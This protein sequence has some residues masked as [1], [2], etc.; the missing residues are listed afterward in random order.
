MKY[1]TKY[2]ELPNID[3]YQA[4]NLAI[5]E[6]KGYPKF[7]TSIYASESPESINGKYYME[8]GAHLQEQWPE[9][10]EGITLVDRVPDV[11][12]EEEV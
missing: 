7:S 5:S 10:L 12:E 8:I 2:A 1:T 4:L 6:A 3:S 9:T 11:I